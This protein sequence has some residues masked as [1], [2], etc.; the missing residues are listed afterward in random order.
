MLRSML[1]A[2]GLLAAVALPVTAQESAVPEDQMIGPMVG[3]EAPPLS[4]M[5]SDGQ[6][7]TLDALAGENGTVIAFIRSLDWCPYCQKQAIG[8]E[9]ARVPLEEAGWS[10]VALSYDSQETLANFSHEKGINYVLVSDPESKVIR[11]YDQLNEEMK[12][13]SKYWGIPHPAIV[14]VRTDG[15]VAAVLREEGYKDRPEV[16]VVTETATLLNEAAGS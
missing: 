5:T 16:D 4:G 2:L 15:T 1:V 7:V 12:E 8:L 10:L 6:T 3:T 11:D 13:G 9:E 14:F